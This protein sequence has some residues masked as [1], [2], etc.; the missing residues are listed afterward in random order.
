MCYFLLQTSGQCEL[1]H[2]DRDG[3]ELNACSHPDP[4]PSVLAPC[5]L[6]LIILLLLL[7][8][9]VLRARSQKKQAAQCRQTQWSQHMQTGCDCCDQ[10][11]TSVEL[12][13][14][15]VPCRAPL[16]PETRCFCPHEQPNT[17]CP[18]LWSSCFRHSRWFPHP[19][20]EKPWT[21]NR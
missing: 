14:C 19:T 3:S 20:V 18:A 17:G 11:D 9:H 6:L 4:E 10:A 1:I 7:C 8:L 16:R 15:Q 2:P 13:Q 12:W 5:A 21:Q